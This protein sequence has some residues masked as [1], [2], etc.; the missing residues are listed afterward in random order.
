MVAC[1]GDWYHA[2]VIMKALILCGGQGTRLRRLTETQPKPMVRVGDR[3]I[4]WHIMK[5]YAHAGVTDFVLCLG[6]KADVIKDYF[7][8]Y[9]ARN[10]DITV[11]LGG[12]SEIELHR[13]GGEEG[14]RVTLTATGENAMTGARVRRGARYLDHDEPFCITYGDGVI[15]LDLRETFAFHR[16][17]PGLVTMTGVRPPSRFG[18]LVHEG[19]RVVSFNE[20]PQVAGGL[21]NGGYFVADPAFLEYLSE[22]DDCILEREPLERCAADG[23]LYAFEHAGYWQCMDTY[24]DWQHLDEQWRSGAAPWKLWT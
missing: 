19:G 1:Q 7:L 20:K 23:Q 17:H 16:S 6:Y 22:E 15:D 10:C 11:T 3:P 13:E 14:W 12:P 4:L 24:R 21:I 8:N 18:E 5:T 9:Q 2:A